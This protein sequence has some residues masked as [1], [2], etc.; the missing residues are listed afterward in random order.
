MQRTV[1]LIGGPADGRV[2]TVLHGVRIKVPH[3]MPGEAEFGTFTYE[4]RAYRTDEGVR[5]HLGVPAGTQPPADL[6]DAWGLTPEQ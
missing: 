1:T 3:K 5:V 6:L 4:I 2:T